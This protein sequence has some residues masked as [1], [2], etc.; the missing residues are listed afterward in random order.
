M[1]DKNSKLHVIQS[2]PLELFSHVGHNLFVLIQQLQNQEINSSFIKSRVEQIT[3]S[4][5]E[6]FDQAFKPRGVDNHSAVVSSTFFKHEKVE[7]F[8]F[9]LLAQLIES[10]EVR[11]NEALNVY[12]ETSS[13][14]QNLLQALSSFEKLMAVIA[15]IYVG[16]QSAGVNFIDNFNYMLLTINDMSL[17]SELI[18]E[19]NLGTKESV[20]QEFINKNDLDIDVQNSITDLDNTLRKSLPDSFQRLLSQTP[21]F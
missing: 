1:S 12:G 19:Y 8:T 11:I 5:Q 13:E 14:K 4:Y 10:F 3:S 20:V 18:A 6:A 21:K 16:K 7:F 15:D 2:Q 17:I 9:K